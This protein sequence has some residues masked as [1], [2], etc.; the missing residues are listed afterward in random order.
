MSIVNCPKILQM[1]HEDT[2]ASY[3]IIFHMSIEKSFD[4]FG[5]QDFV[6]KPNTFFE[7]LANQKNL[8]ILMFPSLIWLTLTMLVL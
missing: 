8:L 2:T 1:F 4:S 3:S 6:K 7:L 5:I